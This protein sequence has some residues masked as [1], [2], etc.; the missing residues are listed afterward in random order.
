ME[1]CRLGIRIYI[2]LFCDICRL[3]DHELVWKYVDWALDKDQELSIKVSISL[4]KIAFL[5]LF[6]C[7]GIQI[8]VNPLY[9]VFL[10]QQNSLQR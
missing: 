2:G 4:S 7:F 10:Y 8:L 6:D 9:T 1:I 3:N 5:P